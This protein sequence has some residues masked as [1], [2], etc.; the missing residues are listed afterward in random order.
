MTA[1]VQHPR[2]CNRQHEAGILR[3]LLTEALGVLAAAEVGR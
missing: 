2:W 1:P 3:D